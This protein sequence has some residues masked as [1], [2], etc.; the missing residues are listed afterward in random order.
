MRTYSH[1][2]ICTD[3]GETYNRP[4]LHEPEA[5]QPAE[6]VGQCNKCVGRRNAENERSTRKAWDKQQAQIAGRRKKKKPDPK[7]EPPEDRWWTP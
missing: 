7:P 1:P 3:C 6:R 2:S 4:S 5:G